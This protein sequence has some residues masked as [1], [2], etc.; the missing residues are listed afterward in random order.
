[1]TM[2]TIVVAV[3]E[4]EPSQRALQRAA[5]LAKA[6]DSH[7][8]VTSVVAANPGAVPRSIG[9]D[10][11]ES[12]SDHRAELT[13]ARRYLEGESLSA[14]YV[15]AAGHEGQSIVAVAL[16]KSADLIV[17]GT[18]EP[19]LLVRLLGNAVSDTV[20]HHARCDVLIVH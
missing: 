1:M 15:E 8:V 4:T 6:F 9:T 18:R 3:D 17:I 10:P 2:K 7:L 13:A 5:T 11:V 20:T 12:E 16:E 14:E 19:P